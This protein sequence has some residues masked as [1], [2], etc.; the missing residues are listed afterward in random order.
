MGLP[1]VSEKEEKEKEKI[2]RNMI[3][4]LSC[5]I[6][7]IFHPDEFSAPVVQVWRFFIFCFSVRSDRVSYARRSACICSLIIVH[8]FIA[9]AKFYSAETLLKSLECRSAPGNNVPEESS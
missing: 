6:W 2:L 4:P 5:I 7:P 9:S 3:D 8:S 1:V